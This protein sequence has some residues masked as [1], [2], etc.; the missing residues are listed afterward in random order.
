MRGL[1]LPTFQS[2]GGGGGFEPPS[3]HFAAYVVLTW[4]NYCYEQFG[5]SIQFKLYSVYDYEYRIAG[6]FGWELSLAF[7]R[8][9]FVTAKIKI[10]Q[11]FIF[12]YKIHMIIPYQTAKFKSANIKFFAL[13]IWGPT[14]NFNSRQYFRPYY[15]MLSIMYTWSSMSDTS[16]PSLLYYCW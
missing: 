7:W 2:G 1:S 8:S 10:R 15:G 6:N 14:T 9:V 5:R 3:L 12:A 16:F 4:Y 11:C 13:V